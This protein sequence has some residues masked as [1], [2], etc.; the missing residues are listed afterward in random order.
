MARVILREASY[1]VPEDVVDEILDELSP[2]LKGKSVLLKPNCLMAA[3]PE[4]GVTTHPS[5]VQAL[6]KSLTDRGARVHVGDNPGARGY[7]AGEHCFRV[8]G[9]L[10]AAGEHFVD[11]GKDTV[12]VKL[13]SPF[14]DHVIVSRLVLESDYVISLPKLKT[15]CLTLLTG[16]VK[17]MYG[18]L[19]GGEKVRL[20]YLARRGEDFS[21]ALVDVFS[22]RPPDLSVMDAVVAMEGDGPSHGTLRTVGMVLASDNAVAVDSAASRLMGTTPGRIRHLAI[23]AERGFGPLDG[24]GVT[25]D[26]ELLPVAGFRLPSTF[27]RGVMNLLSN[28]IVF[29]LLHRSRI[30]VDQGECSGCGECLAACPSG[31][32]FEVEGTY[33][34]DSAACH[35]CFCCHELCP[36]GAVKVR[37]ALGA[38]LKKQRK[39]VREGGESDA[40][41]QAD[42]GIGNAPEKRDGRRDQGAAGDCRR[43]ECR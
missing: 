27:R 17:N 25:F 26:G 34:I 29:N 43:G 2:P 36:S 22:L 18:I 21:G 31:A 14:V 41:R 16:A 23:A 6:V 33:T 39:S 35:Q 19:A 28:S 5:L 42:T 37:G 1:P 20:H 12:R 11:L 30:Q 13:K 7:G 38:L 32:V 10:E 40:C 15:H 24:E 9:L 3:R 8:S 4:E